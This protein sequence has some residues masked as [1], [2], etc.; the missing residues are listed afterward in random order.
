VRPFLTHGR[1]TN[2]YRK[3]TEDHVVQDRGP[4]WQ[5]RAHNDEEGGDLERRQLG[6]Y[7][8]N[9]AASAAAGDLEQVMLVRLNRLSPVGRQ[10]FDL[11][12][13]DEDVVPDAQSRHRRR[14]ELRRALK[15]YAEPLPG[16]D[17]VERNAAFARD[18]FGLD[19]TD[20]EILLL[21]LRYERNAELERLADEVLRRLQSP[22][23][24]LAALLAAEPREIQRRLVA[25]APLIAGGLLSLN[26]DHA[27]VGLAGTCGYCTL[28]RPVRRV[29]L[30]SFDC[31]QDWAAALLGPPLSTPLAWEDFAH[32]GA[33]RD[34]AAAV[35]SGA[36]TGGVRGVNLLL[37]GSIGTGKTEFAKV[38]AARI[39][40]PIW[41]IGET[42]QEGDEPT[43]QERLAA[44][45]LAQ[46]LLC[47]RGPGL[48]LL[49]EA[50]DVL[51]QP[52]A[53]L[54]S[55]GSGREGSKIFV[56]RLLEENPVPV[57]WICNETAGIDPA[58]LRRMTFAMEVATPDRRARAQIWRRMLAEGGLALESAAAER[59]AGRHAI[60]A[61]LAAG[62]VRA[63][64]L[65]G[66][67]EPAI[68]EAIAGLAPLLGLGAAAPDTGG[69]AF[70]PVL[71]SCRD[72]LPGLL[73]RL[74]R[75]DADRR[76]S[77]C[78]HGAP[79]TGKSELARHLARRLG[80]EVLQQ[81]ASDLL[82]PWVGE[83]ERRIAAAFAA[84]RARRAVL[85][86][87]EADSLL[88][89]RRRAERGWEVTQVNEMLTWMESHAL[90]FVCTTNL[91]DRLDPASLRRFTFK[92]RLDPLTPM[93]AAA[94][95]KHFFGMAAP[96]LLSDG[97]TPGDF[98]TVRR[99]RDLLGDTDAEL[100]ANWLDAEAEAK[101]PPKRAMGFVI[102]R[103]R[104]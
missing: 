92:L 50:E 103:S 9:C 56:N 76:W 54:G 44:L 99:K 11:D 58:V 78:I 24:A 12:G 81:R 95:F 102:D 32:L 43:R 86:L 34:L 18:E 68:E 33:P 57:V 77:I 55:F 17:G 87:D 59:L 93:Q 101:E 97:L 5:L 7:L 22:V 52:G 70:D 39:G 75:P 47:S 16:N 63:A 67:G 88:A 4:R 80:L 21:L 42:D 45:K 20:N 64:C 66:G 83:T 27:G 14:R 79:G 3:R 31:R 48:L 2:G 19:A 13:F 96:R 29:M 91:M 72:D 73:E 62:A 30:G 49:D 60:P 61:G 94:A 104:S 82:S 53:R 69:D 51:Q 8:H 23:R 10:A 98:V 37:H 6:W 65:S 36:R 15:R 25:D 26:G 1:A 40:A 85:I 35:G 38:L 89:D 46:R 41:S 71:T 90:P 28:T 74:A 100:L 84:A